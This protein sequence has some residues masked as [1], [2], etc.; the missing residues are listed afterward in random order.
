MTAT[1]P[2]CSSPAVALFLQR[3]KA[4]NPHTAYG[5]VELA[6]VAQICRRL[7][8]L[9]LAIELAA[10]RTSVLGPVAILERLSNP[11]QLLVGGPRDAPARHRA[12]VNTLEWSYQLLDEAAATVLR[13]AA[14]FAGGF[15]LGAA[16]QVCPLQDRINVLDAVA[17][18]TEGSL[19]Q[20]TDGPGGQSRFAMLQ[21]VRDFA[22]ERL[23]SSGEQTLVA[24]AHAY[25]LTGILATAAAA[26]TGP[27]QGQ[28][29]TALDDEHLN[30]L[31]ALRHALA[32]GN[33]DLALEL[34]G[35]LWRYWEIRGQLAEGRYW[36]KQAL[37]LPGG[38]PTARAV[39]LRGAGNLARDHGDYAA[40]Q[41]TQELSL[42]LCREAG[43]RTGEARCLNNLGNI[44]LDQGDSDAAAERYG[45]ALTLGRGLGDDVLVALTSHNLALALRSVGDI[46]AAVVLLHRSLDAFEQL[47]NDREVARCQESLGRLAGA[48]GR[49]E[50]AMTHHVEALRLRL[51]LGDRAGLAR[52]LEGVVIALLGLGD[53][54]RAATLLG[55]AR[56]LREQIAEAY[57]ADERA[58]NV[59]SA[60][61]LTAELG[62]ADF[63]AALE[64][65]RA[66]PIGDLLGW[67]GI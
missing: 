62:A 31:A 11:L 67:L 21:T 41:Q 33:V 56:R 42:T 8:G 7:D 20:R 29:L 32:T 25:Y 59:T 36:L 44:A 45:E 4:A 47:G 64:Q 18:L 12:L 19:L 27:D 26:L 52:S 61:R 54:R 2:N 53:A 46:A 43:D 3:A 35:H 40:A 22:Q 5:P 39:A 13:R 48:Q 24:A 55:A 30:A 14:V 50:E 58:D 66:S 9:P 34:A 10:A 51:W 57:T 38:S 16:E 63:A 6:A 37:A 23:A 17:T 15:T 60:D 1:E 65:G 49:F 28:W